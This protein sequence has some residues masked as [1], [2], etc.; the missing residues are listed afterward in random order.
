MPAIGPYRDSSVTWSS[1]I[2][3]GYQMQLGTTAMGKNPALRSRDI[4]SN[5]LQASKR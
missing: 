2:T 5:C 4:A 3:V 1:S